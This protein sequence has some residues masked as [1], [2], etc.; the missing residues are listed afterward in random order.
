VILISGEP[1]IGKSAL[2]ETVAADAA[3]RGFG[4][5]LG[6]AEESDR[7]APLAPLLLAL[8]SGPAPLLADDVFHDLAEFDRGLPRR[9]IPAGAGAWQL[10]GLRQWMLLPIAVFSAPV[11][12]PHGDLT[13]RQLPSRSAAATPFA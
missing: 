1:G 5:G 7:I 12:R 4:Y 2:A 11:V 8:R 9:L 6:K 10:G 3:G 13:D